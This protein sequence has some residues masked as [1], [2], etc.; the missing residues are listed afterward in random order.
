MS[1]ADEPAAPADV[2]KLARLRDLAAAALAPDSIAVVRRAGDD[3]DQGRA[4]WGGP[5]PAGDQAPGADLIAWLPD[6]DAGTI[7]HRWPHPD[8]CPATTPRDA[9]T[10][11]YGRA[12][13]WLKATPCR[14]CWPAE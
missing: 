7:A 9:W 8:A 2:D 14:H 12:L 13:D 4:A 5:T 10:L 6:L 1:A 3:N 11:P